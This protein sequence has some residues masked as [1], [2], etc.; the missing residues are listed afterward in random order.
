[1]NQ[2]RH[3]DAVADRYDETIPPHVRGHYLRK[4]VGL[5]EPLF[6]NG[7]VLDVGCGTGVLVQALREAGVRALGVDASGPMLRVM[8]CGD[9]GPGTRA[10]SE[11]LPFR[12]DAFDGV[13]CVA[14]LH[15]LADRDAVAS[16]VA[17]MVRVTRP[18]GH[19]V[20]WD[21]NPANPYWPCIMARVPQDSG[22]ERLVPAAEIVAASRAAGVEWIRV[23]RLGLVPDFAPRQLLWFFR[24]VEFLVER[25]PLVN[26]LCAHNV[27]V[28]RK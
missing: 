27:V 23:Y 10:V 16:T 14:L 20:I 19:V 28:G 12:N 9:R 2:P 7:R 8:R 6:P 21:H 18:G 11:R 4:R 22:T 13:V 26:G 17:D 25:L 3:F 24:A 1:M 15:H 5:M